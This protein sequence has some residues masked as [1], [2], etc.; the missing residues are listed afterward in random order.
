MKGFINHIKFI[1]SYYIAIIFLSVFISACT[2]RSDMLFLDPSN[3]IISAK[4]VHQQ[5]TFALDVLFVVESSNNNFLSREVLNQHI[6]YLSEVLLSQKEVID[7]HIGFTIASANKDSAFEFFNN[8]NS[9]EMFSSDVFYVETL[10]KILEIEDV[11]NQQ[12]FD[13]VSRVLVSDGAIEG[14]FYR[15]EA[16]LLLVFVGEDD[17]GESTGVDSLTQKILELKKYQKEKINVLSVYSIFNKC[18]STDDL[19]VH[20]LRE[21]AK[22]FNGHVF[23]L[24]HPIFDKLLQV[25][26]IVYQNVASIPLSRIP[27]L[28]TV[29][30]CYGSY[31][32]SQNALRGWSYLPQEN[33]ITLAWDVDLNSP[34]PQGYS[35]AERLDLQATRDS[36][37]RLS[38]DSNKSDPYLFDLNYMSTS[39]SHIAKKLLTLSKKP[40][41]IPEK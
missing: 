9:D 1:N 37:F 26:Q 34:Q 22:A 14:Q 29:A 28:E 3:A 13:A 36:A 38:C 20:H 33:K 27:L 23:Y 11:N 21:F 19:E 39:P 41:S 32:I 12:F 18:P 35:E 17:Q 2:K 6:G 30:L 10:E 5:K 7:L 40:V 31:S 16:D 15:S 4:S 24:C 25:A 8:E